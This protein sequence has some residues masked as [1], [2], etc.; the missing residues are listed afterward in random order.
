MRLPLALLNRTKFD[1]WVE[2]PEII[3]DL[4]KGGVDIQDVPL[5][6]DLPSGRCSSYSIL[7]LR[8]LPEDEFL[9]YDSDEVYLD[10]AKQFRFDVLGIVAGDQ[11]D[12]DFAEFR[13][14]VGTLHDERW[15]TLTWRRPDKESSP[16]WWL[17]NPCDD[18]R[19]QTPKLLS[20][21]LACLRLELQEQRLATTSK[22]LRERETRS[23]HNSRAAEVIHSNEQIW[24]LVGGPPPEVLLAPTA[25]ALAAVSDTCAHLEKLV[26]ANKDSHD[27]LGVFGEEVLRAARTLSSLE[28]R[29]IREERFHVTPEG[30]FDEIVKNVE[31]IARRSA[32]EAKRRQAWLAENDNEEGE[33]EG[34]AADEP[35]V[36]TPG[37]RID[38]YGV[39]LDRFMSLG[40]KRPSGWK[41]TVKIAGWVQV[42]E[43][44]TLLELHYDQL[45]LERY[46]ALGKTG[47]KRRSSDYK[48]FGS[49][50][51]A[52]RLKLCQRISLPDSVKQ[53]FRCPAHEDKWE[54]LEEARLVIARC[55]LGERDV[56]VECEADADEI[57]AA[58]QRSSSVYPDALCG[59]E[60]FPDGSRV[61]VEQPPGNLTVAEQR[62]MICTAILQSVGRTVTV[63]T[64]PLTSN[65]PID[66]FAKAVVDPAMNVKVMSASWR[67]DASTPEAILDRLL[68]VLFDALFLDSCLTW[69]AR[70]VSNCHCSETLPLAKYFIQ[71]LCVGDAPLFRGMCAFC[72]RLLTGPA[73]NIVGSK[74]GPP[75]NRSGQRVLDQSGAPDLRAQPPCLLRYSPSLFAK[76]APAAFEHDPATNCLTLKPGQAPPWL[77]QSEKAPPGDPNIWLYCEDCYTQFIGPADRRK[78]ARGVPFRDKA[79]QCVMKPT[80][81]SQQRREQAG[82][83]AP[84][85]VAAAE[86]DFECGREEEQEERSDVADGD[87]GN[88][89]AD[90]AGAI[91][92]PESEPEAEPPDAKAKPGV[93]AEDNASEAGSADDGAGPAEAALPVLLPQE[94]RPSLEQYRDKWARLLAQHSKRVEGEFSVWNLVPTPIY[95]L[96][97]DCPHVP[98]E[99]LR[100]E[101]SQA[102]LSVCKPISG[103]QETTRVGGVERYAHNSGEASRRRYK[104]AQ[105]PRRTLVHANTRSRTRTADTLTDAR[106][107]HP[108]MRART[109]ARARRYTKPPPS[110]SEPVEQLAR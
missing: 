20:R 28:W 90:D 87:L 5:F 41:E 82:V 52:H 1:S 42:D 27:G 46:L 24:R 22:V 105:R 33:G 21:S 97:Q 58:L 62:A 49:I 109:H 80:W 13:E 107:P 101:E 17:V 48:V 99:E 106:T 110:N 37:A 35:A 32:G 31:A 34:I 12:K 6:W 64:R 65:P 89:G 78:S 70:N 93:G 79:S 76:E 95:E 19:T 88:V 3:Q 69:T 75:I 36:R 53:I 7:Q 9:P 92:E 85:G 16:C 67:I 47:Q 2:R 54:K 60:R 102:R 63:R 38:E 40:G 50:A 10:M 23:E 44:R 4:P 83:E 8:S 84:A 25:E 57:I 11:P 91:G 100:S 43:M 14:D 108:H 30:L 56:D 55:I 15:K 94:V 59:H 68:L 39:N 29:V 86:L 81:R 74:A 61:L 18:D 72:A 103:L 26:E 45:H 71:G 66:S 77:R 104:S 73:E 96:W 98:F 51:Q